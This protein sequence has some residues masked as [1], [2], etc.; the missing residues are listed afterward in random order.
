MTGGDSD[1]AA[2]HRR[3]LL[4]RR[5]MLDRQR[6][7]LQERASQQQQQQ[8][9]QHQQ[10]QVPAA[11]RRQDSLKLHSSSRQDEDAPSPPQ[12]RKNASTQTNALQLGLIALHPKAKKAKK[13]KNEQEE[14]SSQP[15]LKFPVTLG[16]KPLVQLWW[17]AC[18]EASDK[19]T[20]QQQQQRHT[21][22]SKSCHVVAQH[23]SKW[24][25]SMLDISKHGS[26]EAVRCDHYLQRRSII[27]EDEDEDEQI[28]QV[29]KLKQGDCL[30]VGDVLSIGPPN[31]K[32]QPPAATTTT[33]TTT[34]TAS[35]S[36]SWMRF[37]VVPVP[38]HTTTTTTTSESMAETDENARP[39]IKQQRSRQ[40]KRQQNQQ[41]QK[42][43]MK[44]KLDSDDDD[45]S[46]V[47]KKSSNEKK[48]SPGRARRGAWTSSSSEG[49]SEEEDEHTRAA[50]RPLWIET[51]V[52]PRRKRRHQPLTSIPESSKSSSSSEASLQHKNNNSSN[53]ST[54]SPPPLETQKHHSPYHH[55]AMLLQPRP[56][57]SIR[58]PSSLRV[59]S[60]NVSSFEPSVMAPATFAPKKHFR[61]AILAEQP[62]I[63]C[64]QE[65]PLQDTERVTTL[66]EGF[67][68]LGATKSHCQYATVFLKSEWVPFCTRITYL[69][70]GN[71]NNDD[72]EQG[73]APCTLVR[74]EFAHQQSLL[75]GSCHL[76]PFQQGA[77]RRLEQVHAIHQA[78][79]YEGATASIIAGDFNMRLREGKRKCCRHVRITC[80]YILRPDRF[81]YRP[82]YY[83]CLCRRRRR[84]LVEGRLERDGGA[85]IRKEYVGQS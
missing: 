79:V 51:S 63:I 2:Q 17:K 11:A 6:Q 78:V 18:D 75:I 69:G 34:T 46:T 28:V 54:T 13:Q 84:G 80:F 55:G 8:Q 32:P 83:S 58:F 61:E 43:T 49:E 77:Q 3:R 10:E 27:M 50:R 56:T 45:D 67:E 64:L 36:S 29:Q 76:A 19:R 35:A 42:E 25:N 74:M 82:Y 57:P 5:V 71:G 30:R 14:S 24:S 16:R 15:I 59:V 39:I 31:P 52:K 38:V 73:G 72:Y 23:A 20:Q 70:G 48:V 53:S 12:H 1:A 65:V 85:T 33:T 7:S 22:H 40:Q 9:Q 26:I 68:C 21:C 4:R 37:Q 62:D 47:E 44:M 81:K 41:T 60:L 66:I